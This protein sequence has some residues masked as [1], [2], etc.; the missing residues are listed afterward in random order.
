M[1]K[2]K[3]NFHKAQKMSLAKIMILEILQDTHKITNNDDVKTLRRFQKK[4]GSIELVSL[5]R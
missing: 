5:A 4:A 2:V 3:A 1:K